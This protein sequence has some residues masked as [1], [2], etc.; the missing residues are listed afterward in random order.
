MA[1]SF[2]ITFCGDTSLGYYYLDRSREKYPKAYERLQNNPISFFDGVLPILAKSDEVIVNLE[3]VLSHDPGKPIE[4]KQYPGCDDPE[5]TIEV[6]KELGVTAVTLANNHT[7]DFGPDKLL[8]MIEKL[9]HNGIATI[10]AG[11]NLEEARRPYRIEAKFGG[12][13]KNVYVFNGMRAT[14]R[15]IKYGFFAGKD[16][17]GIA[18]TNSNGMIR[19]IRKVKALDSDSIVIVCPHWQG[20]DYQDTSESHAQWCRKII[21]AGAD[22]IVAHGSHKADTVGSYNGGKVF[23]SIGNFVFN[24]PGRYRVKKAEPYSLVPR[25]ILGNAG[26]SPNGDF[27]VSKIVTDNRAT[28]FNVSVCKED[29]GELYGSLLSEVENMREQGIGMKLQDFIRMIGGECRIHFEGTYEDS[30][31]GLAYAV[32]KT[33]SKYW[34]ILMGSRFSES[35]KKKYGQAADSLEELILRCEHRGINRFVAPMSMRGKS[36][37]WISSAFLLMIRL[38]FSIRQQ[39]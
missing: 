24:S 19:G 17:P 13:V 25:L 15:Y 34:M 4:G 26:E 10:G 27:S 31:L 3:T 37:F 23:F 28:N 16:S 12:Q 20:I 2:E 14:R 29:N 11:I 9:Q 8:S 18:S 21:D 5:V 7:M 35:I 30:F 22:H 32:Q 6:L 33:N 39:G 36:V 1:E 38:S